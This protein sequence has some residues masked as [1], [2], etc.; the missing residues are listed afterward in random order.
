MEREDS[1]P[2]IVDLGT[3]SHVTQGGLGDM[4]EPTGLWHKAGISDE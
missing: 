1:A 4:I 2:A 3:A